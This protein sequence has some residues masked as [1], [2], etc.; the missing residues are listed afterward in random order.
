LADLLSLDES[1]AR[2]LGLLPLRL[3][4]L[5]ERAFA[6]GGRLRLEDFERMQ[7]EPLQAAGCVGRSIAVFSRGGSF[8]GMMEAVGDE[9]SYRF[10]IGAGS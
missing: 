7:G 2:A 1:S 9:L 10:V 8:R 3:R 5:A 6:N 4:E